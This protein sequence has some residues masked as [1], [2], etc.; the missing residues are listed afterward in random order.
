MGGRRKKPITP[1]SRIKSALGAVWLRSRERGE[2]V[3]LAG[4]I[5]QCCGKKGSA[6]K[7]REVKI[8]V[9]HIEGGEW[10]K[11]IAYIRRVL[12]VDPS[13]LAVVCSDC[14]KQI[15]ETGEF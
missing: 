11:I 4:N 9:H 8:E 14:H 12:L 6:A 15:H 1:A 10:D 3:R 5:C 2:A 7:G 13:K